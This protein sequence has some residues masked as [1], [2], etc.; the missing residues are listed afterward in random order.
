MTTGIFMPFFQ[1]Y[2]LGT[3]GYGDFYPQTDLGRGVCVIAIF[4][5]IFLVSIMVVTL[6]NSSSFDTKK[7]QAIR[8]L[9]PAQHSRGNQAKGEFC[10]GFRHKNKGPA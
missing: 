2:Y 6:T 10:C 5:G 4:W 3:V 9:A 7:G 1:A 8:F